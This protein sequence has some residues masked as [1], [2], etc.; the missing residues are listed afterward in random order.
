M[1]NPYS[2]MD[3]TLLGPARRRAW[4]SAMTSLGAHAPLLPA[5]L[6]RLSELFSPVTHT[7]G[8]WI[9]GVLPIACG[10]LTPSHPNKQTTQRPSESKM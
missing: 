1:H 6:L 5:L 3:A 9:P 4:S 8:A 10:C 2:C 7:S